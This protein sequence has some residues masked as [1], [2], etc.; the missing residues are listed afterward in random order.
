[1]SRDP[2][3]FDPQHNPVLRCSTDALRYAARCNVIAFAF[4]LMREMGLSWDEA[5][6]EIADVFSCSK[7]SVAREVNRAQELDEVFE[8]VQRGPVSS[9]QVAR[10]VASRLSHEYE[11]VF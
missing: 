4:N 2:L 1:M 6:E 7:S 3:P 11:S 8:R 10:D 5:T 9:E